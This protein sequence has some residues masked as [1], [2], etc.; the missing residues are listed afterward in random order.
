MSKPRVFLAG[1][2]ALCAAMLA[3]VAANATSYT[4][5]YDTARPAGPTSDMTLD[6]PTTF[7]AAPT[8]SGSFMFDDVTKAF[9]NVN[10]Q[11]SDSQNPLSPRNLRFNFTVSQLTSFDAFVSLRGNLFSVGP[12]FGQAITLVNERDTLD[13][14]PTAVIDV[15]LLKPFAN[16]GSLSSVVG[17]SMAIDWIVRKVD[18]FET[19]MY[20]DSVVNTHFMV[21]ANTPAVPEPAQMALLLAGLLTVGAMARRR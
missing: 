2:A 19:Q 9:S 10:V 15:P 8:V 7:L 4:F 21:T 11:F 18:G 12:W 5:T 20:Q 16:G 6:Y 14:I 13:R 1:M 3:P 17:T